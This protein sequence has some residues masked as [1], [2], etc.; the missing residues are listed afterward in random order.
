MQSHPQQR[1][2]GTALGPTMPPPL[3][4]P[5]PRYYFHLV[6][7]T[8]RLDDPEG[9]DLASVEEAREEAIASSREQAAEALRRGELVPWNYYEI[10]DMRAPSW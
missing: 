1:G 7:G 3:G 4:P 2:G 8:E 5:M 10:T 9:S 6:N